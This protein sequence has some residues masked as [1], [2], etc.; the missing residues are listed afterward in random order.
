[1]LIIKIIIIIILANYSLLVSIIKKYVI[2]HSIFIGTIGF[3]N[4]KKN[5]TKKNLIK[6]V[7]TKLLLR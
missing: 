2:K 3:E 1:M 5:K 6:F 4:I 7:N